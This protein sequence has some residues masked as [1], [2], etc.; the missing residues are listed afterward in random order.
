MGNVTKREMQREIFIPFEQGDSK[1]EEL[2]DEIISLRKKQG[3]VELEIRKIND[4]LKEPKYQ[5]KS[6]IAD[7]EH[8]VQDLTKGRPEKIDC[9][10]EKRFDDGVVVYKTLDGEFIDERPLNESDNQIEIGS[11]ESQ[12]DHEESVSEDESDVENEESCNPYDDFEPPT[13][14]DEE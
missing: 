8:A 4:K 12:E 3:E 13:S 10:E 14:F 1:R 5:L 9:I 7:L 2:C 6:I 11:T